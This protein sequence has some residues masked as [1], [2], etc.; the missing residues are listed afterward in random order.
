LADFPKW[1]FFLILRTKAT[2]A[3]EYDFIVIIVIAKAIIILLEPKIPLKRMLLLINTE[4][5]KILL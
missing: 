3:F 5:N 1:H 4:K 2:A